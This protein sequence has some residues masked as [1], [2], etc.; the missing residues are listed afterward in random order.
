MRHMECMDQPQQSA[1]YVDAVSVAI[2]ERGRVLLVKRGKQPSKGMYAFPGG[3]VEPGETLVAAAHREL[4]EETALLAEALVELEVM[5]FEPSRPGWSGYVLTVFAGTLAGGTLAAG[6][7]AAEAGW[8]TPDE[9]AAMPLTESTSIIAARL[10]ENYAAMTA[11][12][13]CR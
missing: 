4:M 3:R 2:V 7:D 10:F 11:P 5:R 13:A 1:A 9:I 6:D 8:F 12:D